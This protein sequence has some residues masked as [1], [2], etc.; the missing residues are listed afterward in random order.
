MHEMKTTKENQLL[1]SIHFHFN[2]KYLC[3]AK[4]TCSP[5]SNKGPT[6]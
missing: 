4:A 3:I 2:Q 5:N 1:V 6:D